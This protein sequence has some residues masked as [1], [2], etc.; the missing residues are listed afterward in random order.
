M[1]ERRID[2]PTI[3]CGFCCMVL[4][5]MSLQGKYGK[6]PDERTG[7]NWPQLKG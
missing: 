5:R 1:H 3:L 7:L 2:R 6:Q 4:Q